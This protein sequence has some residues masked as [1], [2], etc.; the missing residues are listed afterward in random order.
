[1]GSAS[2]LL[3]IMSCVPLAFC[4][5]IDGDLRNAVRLV[6]L[7]PFS[8]PLL[9]FFFLVVQVGFSRMEA[10]VCFKISGVF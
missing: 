8:F 5:Y 9:F 3:K 10:W 7:L 1:M 2:K 4:A 6:F